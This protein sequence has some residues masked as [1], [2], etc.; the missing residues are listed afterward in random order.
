MAR[1]GGIPRGGGRGGVYQAARGGN[2]NG[3]G[4]GGGG[5]QTRGGGNMNPGAA[6][7]SPTANNKRPHDDSQ[8]GGAQ[9]KKIRG[10][11]HGS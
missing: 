5:G 2:M 9:P 4:R 3:R 7:F 8:Q 10:G 6:S 11:G 1:G